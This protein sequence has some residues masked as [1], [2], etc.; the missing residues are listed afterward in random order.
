MY[1]SY[2]AKFYPRYHK[3]VW[4]KIARSDLCTGD[5]EALQ[6]PRDQRS[7]A[8]GRR[9]RVLSEDAAAVGARFG[10]RGRICR[11][12]EGAA[13]PGRLGPVHGHR[14]VKTGALG[15]AHF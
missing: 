6:R 14:E 5:G 11:R 12:E 1:L 4:I 2:I 7:G 15:F 10:R 8:G 13:A 3:C 9:G